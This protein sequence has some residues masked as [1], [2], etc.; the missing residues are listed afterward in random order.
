[1]LTT[2]IPVKSYFGVDYHEVEVGDVL[3]LAQTTPLKLDCGEK[4]SNFPI[5]FQAYGT[6]NADK[7]N[8]ILICHALTGDQYV[9]SPNPVTGK[10]GWWNT[11]IGSRQHHRHGTLL[12]HLLQRTGW[13]HG[14]FWPQR[15]QS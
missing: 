11:L 10:P 6:L 15:G 4:I 5:A 1:M 8:A 2:A 13:L 12:R 14:F 9:A 7:S 3:Q